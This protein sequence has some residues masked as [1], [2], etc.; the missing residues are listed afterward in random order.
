MQEAS[1]GLLNVTVLGDPFVLATQT[2]E[3]PKLTQ[4]LA[5]KLCCAAALG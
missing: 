1:S 3:Q 4:F 5:Y 2:P